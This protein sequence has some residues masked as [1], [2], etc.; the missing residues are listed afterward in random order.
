MTTC[1]LLRGT[2]MSYN[3]LEP[4]DDIALTS[5]A[6]ATCLPQAS[7]IPLWK[8][9]FETWHIAVF[10][11]GLI[12]GNIALIMSGLI[13]RP[14]PGAL[15][16]EEVLTPSNPTFSLLIITTV[17]L[18]A[19]THLVAWAQVWMGCASTGAQTRAAATA[20]QPSKLTIRCV[21]STHHFA[22]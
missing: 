15:S 16:L 20:L 12:G 5:A 21:S 3:K 1:Q 13:D 7:L 14:T 8:D 17:V 4:V 19:K 11:V 6:S 2:A 9:G 10:I 22:A 18:F